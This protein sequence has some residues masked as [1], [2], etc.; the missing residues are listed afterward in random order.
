MKKILPLL[1]AFAIVLLN[2]CSKTG[3]SPGGSGGNNGGN[4]GGGNTNGITVTSVTPDRPYPDDQITITGTGFKADATKD[5]VEFG[6][7]ISG[8]FGAWHDGLDSQWASRCTVVS[9]TATQLVVRAVNTFQLDYNSFAS[10][11]SSI[12]VMQVRT[13]GKKAVTPVVPFKRLLLLS[14]ITNPELFNDAI[15]RPNDS[16]VIGGKGFAKSGVSVSIDGTPLTDFKIDSTPEYGQITLRLPSTF[17][18]G[19]NDESLMADKSMTLTNPDGKSVQKTFHFLLSP[20]M[21]VYGMQ[22]ESSSYSLSGLNGSGGVVKVFVSGRA[23]KDD[24]VVKLGGVN[25]QSQAGLQVTGFPNSTVITFSAGSLAL[26]TLQVSIWRGNT[27]YGAC[28]FKVNQ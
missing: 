28:T 9:A 6:R 15:G 4:N 5:T 10:G 2:S 26:G 14:S 7:L 23:L 3:S 19:A 13:G 20:Q 17:F 16:L 18:G 21:Q 12:A 24:A 25:I 8:K 11:P 27:L 1:F 22:A